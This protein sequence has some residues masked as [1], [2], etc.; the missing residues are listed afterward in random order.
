MIAQTFKIFAS[1]LLT[2]Q[3]GITGLE[4]AVLLTA[5]TVASSSLGLA[6]M[7]V[8]L[9]ASNEIQS[10]VEQTLLSDQFLRVAPLTSTLSTKASGLVTPIPSSISDNL[11][12][13]EAFPHTSNVGPEALADLIGLLS[14]TGTPFTAVVMSDQS[15][16]K[17]AS[18]DETISLEPTAEG[19]SS[20]T[21]NIGPGA[22]ADV[23]GLLADTGTPF[24]AVVMSDESVWTYV[25]GD[26]TLQSQAA[27][28]TAS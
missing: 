15:V 1:E 7:R 9:S 5:L 3:K 6:Y 14:D 23:I 11:D 16:W 22:L 4:T 24:T 28:P 10:R 12:S 2:G 13:A 25:V 27:E 26:D 21:S 20:Q 17:Y 19:S 18:G 8:S